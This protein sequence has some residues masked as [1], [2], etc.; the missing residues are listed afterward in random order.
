[1]AR[2]RVAKEREVFVQPWAQ[3][4]V[5]KPF[6]KIAGTARQGSAIARKFARIG[7]SFSGTEYRSFTKNKGLTKRFPVLRT[8][9]PGRPVFNFVERV[10]RKAHEIAGQ[11]SSRPAR[12][13][14]DLAGAGYRRFK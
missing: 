3:Q 2:Q 4:T 11:A 9:F 14:P 13:G 1:V 12:F 7:M 6:N 8:R 5:I 10:A